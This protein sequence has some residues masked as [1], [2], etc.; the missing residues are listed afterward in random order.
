MCGKCV[1]RYAIEGTH[2]LTHDPTMCVCTH[3]ACAVRHVKSYSSGCVV[4]ACTTGWRVDDDESE[5][6]ANVCSCSNG[7]ASSGDKCATHGGKMCDSCNSGF[8]LSQDKTACDG[9]CLVT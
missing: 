5:C 7:V 3:L 2:A 1:C 8:K 6:L 9:I 4:S